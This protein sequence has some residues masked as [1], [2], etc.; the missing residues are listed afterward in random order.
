MADKKTQD[1]INAYDDSQVEILEGLKH[2]LKRPSMYLGALDTPQHG[3]EEALMNSLDEVKVGVADEINIALHKDK[4]ISIQDNGRGIPPHYSDKFKMPTARA[5]LTVPNTGKGLASALATGSSQNG[6]GMKATVAT[7]EWMDVKIWRD[8]TEWTDRYE[9]KGKDPGVPVVKLTRAGELPSTK[10]PKSAP[11][12]GSYLHWLP[13]AKVFDSLDLRSKDI[14]SLCEFQTFLNPGLKITVDVK[15]KVHEMFNPGGLS[16]LIERLAKQVDAKLMTP[17]YQFPAVFDTGAVVRDDNGEEHAV[18]I[19]GTIAYA[20]SNATNHQTMLYTNNV[21]NPN[22]GTPVRGSFAGISKLIN[23]YAKELNMSKSTIDQRDILPGLILVLNLT[24]PNPKFDGQTKKEITSADAVG[25]LNSM[26]YNG[27]QIFFDRNIEPI[28]DVIKQALA[29]AAERKKSEDE[30]I[31]VS[32]NDANKALSQKLEP[33]R[34]TGAGSGAELFIVE[35]D[36]AGG[37][38]VD[39]RDPNLQAVIPVRGKTLNTWKTTNAK[40]MSNAEIVA[41]LTAIGTGVGKDFDLSKRNY[42][43][44]IITTDQDPDG[45][46][47]SCLLL[48]TFL[49]YVPDLLLGGYIYRVIT[50]LFVNTFKDKKKAPHYTY[51]NKEQ[52]VFLKSRA[53]KTVTGIKRNKGIGEVSPELVSESIINSGTRRLLRYQIKEEFMDDALDVV[54]DLMGDSTDARKAIFFNPDIYEL[55]EDTETV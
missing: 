3:L 46:H 53:G 30:K 42:D 24:H 55:V 33:S 2:I 29:R 32:R 38:V 28:K 23:R 6:I 37:T 19:S 13:N 10:A 27:S 31:N 54:N 15:G 20:W 16:T 1:L 40:A 18:V 4:S 35:G 12:H 45:A 41:I 49:K 44:I 5:L 51:S 43:K 52:Q 39:E 7:S 14:L 36:S 26:I 47:I 17:V 21:P 25:A 9:L 34:K 8:G 50:P 11:A 22:G 48:T